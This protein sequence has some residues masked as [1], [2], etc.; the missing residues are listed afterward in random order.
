[1]TLNHLSHENKCQCLSTRLSYD[2]AKHWR[3]VPCFKIEKHTSRYIPCTWLNSILAL[4]QPC[5]FVRCLAHGQSSCVL[6]GSLCFSCPGDAALSVLPLNY[7]DM[8][9]HEGN[10][11][12]SLFLNLNQLL[13]RSIPTF[14]INHYRVD[15]QRFTC[16]ALVC[17]CQ[18]ISHTS[19][20]GS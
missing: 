4:S 3:K 6:I 16:L 8:T 11:T 2:E 14:M 18:L 17:A 5:R 1:M 7:I 9:R 12:S 15:V 20:S 19:H 13:L 10:D